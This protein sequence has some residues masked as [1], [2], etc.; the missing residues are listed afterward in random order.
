MLPSRTIALA[1]AAEVLGMSRGEFSV[2]LRIMSFQ[3]SYL[4]DGE[5]AEEVEIREKLKKCTR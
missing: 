4:D 2:V 3:Y 5:A 1:E